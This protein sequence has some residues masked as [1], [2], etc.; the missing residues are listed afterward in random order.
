VPIK[1]SRLVY[2]F[3][4]RFDRF[5]GEQKPAIRLENK[6]SLLNEGLQIFF[7]NR[8]KL[9]EVNS[10]VRDELR[11]LEEKERSLKLRILTPE[12]TL[13]A[14]PKDSFKILRTSATISKKDCPKK[15]VPIIMVGT[16]DLTRARKNAYWRSSFEWEHVLADEAKDGLYLY[17]DGEFS[18]DEVIIDY[19]RRPAELHA[20]SMSSK[21]EYV[22]WN[23]ELRRKDVDL[24]LDNT[25]AYRR[26]VDIA[27]L[28][29]QADVGDQRDFQLKLTQILQAEPNF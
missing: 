18:I 24:E 25:Y 11:P 10:R 19:Y 1:T 15:T 13:A 27:V 16:D 22:D 6:L 9:A 23:G 21:K 17:N 29:A 28:I 26:I 14:I 8:V 7:E 4:R 20:P 5:T 2:E 3:D 12:I